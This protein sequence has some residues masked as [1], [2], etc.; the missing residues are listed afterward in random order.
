VTKKNTPKSKTL[1]Q[2]HR[3]VYKWAYITIGIEVSILWYRPSYRKFR[4]ALTRLG[5]AD[6]VALQTNCVRRTCSSNCFRRGLNPCSPP[7][8][9]N[10][11][12]TVPHTTEYLPDSFISHL[13]FVPL[14]NLSQFS[15]LSLRQIN[16]CIISKHISWNGAVWSFPW[17]TD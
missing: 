12:T 13:C 14:C 1:R 15:D 6:A 17:W 2:A 7:I 8:K 11:S 4:T 5:G 10:Q 3:H 16:L 9:P